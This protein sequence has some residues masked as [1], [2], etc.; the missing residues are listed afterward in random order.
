MQ[1]DQTARIIQP[2][3]LPTWPTRPTSQIP[4]NHA[5]RCHS[6]HDACSGPPLSETAV[7]VPDS[8]RPGFRPLPT[9]HCRPCAGHLIPSMCD[10]RRKPNPFSSLQSHHRQSF[11]LLLPMRI[12]NEPCHQPPKLPPHFWH[13]LP[14]KAPSWSRHSL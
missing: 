12:A 13:R 11:A 3:P 5:P 9:S 10:Q 4:P 14:K 6:E 8:C 2:R 7:A 1:Q